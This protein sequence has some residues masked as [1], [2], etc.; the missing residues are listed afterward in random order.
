MGSLFTKFFKWVVRVTV[1]GLLFSAFVMPELVHYLGFDPAAALATFVK[2]LL[3]MHVQ[4]IPVMLVRPRL[5]Y[6]LSFDSSGNM[7]DLGSCN[8]PGCRL[9]KLALERL[10]TP[11]RFGAKGPYALDC[12]GLVYQVLSEAGMSNPPRS[13]RAQYRLGS[14]VPKKKLAPGDMVFFQTWRPGPS[15]VG[16]YIGR[17]LFVNASSSQGMVVVEHLD[18]RY[19]RMRYIGARRVATNRLGP[20]NRSL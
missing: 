20:R 2:N 19:Y 12:S 15:H 6:P 10:G 1:I 5:V 14:S 7:P 8:R 18:S 3:P 13:A 11:Y 4:S 16:V 9:A 17:G